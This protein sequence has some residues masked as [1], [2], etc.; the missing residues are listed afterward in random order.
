MV[1]GPW[2]NGMSFLTSS[3]DPSIRNSFESTGTH[4]SEG[5]SKEQRPYGIEA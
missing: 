2:A 3:P 5:A 1:D 4:F